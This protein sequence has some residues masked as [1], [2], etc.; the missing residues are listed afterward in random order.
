MGMFAW[1][2]PQNLMRGQ[3]LDRPLDDPDICRHCDAACCRAFA[4][5]ELTWHE[6]E[7][8]R[9]LGA[10]RLSF[11]LL[12]QPRLLIDAG[13]EFLLNDRC[14][15][16]AQRPDICRR[17]VCTESGSPASAS[18]EAQHQPH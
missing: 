13:C 6:Y 5:V 15:I 10:T 18:S 17:F 7:T 3:L 8:L 16:Y 12:G 4:S 9:A 14:R 1:Q 2:A 11:P